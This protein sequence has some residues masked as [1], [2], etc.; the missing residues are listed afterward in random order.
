MTMIWLRG[1]FHEETNLIPPRFT[2]FLSNNPLLWKQ[3]R[4][5]G[6]HG[7]KFKGPYSTEFSPSRRVEGSWRSII[8]GAS[9]TGGTTVSVSRVLYD[10]SNSDPYPF[11]KLIKDILQSSSRWIGNRARI[12]RNKHSIR[13]SSGR[14]REGFHLR[15]FFLFASLGVCQDTNDKQE[16]RGRSRQLFKSSFISEPRF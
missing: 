11:V 4:A 10:R 5:Q 8:T 9:V 16:V 15:I 7:G 1:K 12:Y 14:Y 6:W 3:Q 13:P 2:V